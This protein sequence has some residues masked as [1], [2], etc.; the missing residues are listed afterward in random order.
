MEIAAAAPRIGWSDLAY[1]LVP[2]GRTLDYRSRARS[3]QRAIFCLFG[4][5]EHD[6]FENVLQELDA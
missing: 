2:T 6:V 1:A 4:K 5:E 3:L